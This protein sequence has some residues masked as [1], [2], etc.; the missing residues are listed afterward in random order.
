MSHP[1]IL[2]ADDDAVSM[3]LL[4]QCLAGAGFR[5]VCAENGR[6]ALLLMRQE[7][8]ALVI[9][10]VMMPVMEGMEV[11]RHAKA[12]A[13]LRLTPV[14]ML[15]SRHQDSDILDA[16][17]VGAADYLVKPFDPSELLAR[18]ARAIGEQRCVA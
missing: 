16:L 7:S 6:E 10:D 3:F 18:V 17:K 15:T 2:V 8:P 13:K 11:L 1:T 9:L 12:D 4:R 14:I 5:V